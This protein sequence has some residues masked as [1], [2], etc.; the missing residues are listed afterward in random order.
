[1]A[2]ILEVSDL[3]R[4]IIRTSWSMAS[5][6]WAWAKSLTWS[7]IGFLAGRPLRVVWRG[8][9]SWSCCFSRSALFL[10]LVALF[11]PCQFLRLWHPIPAY[12]TLSRNVNKQSI[13]SAPTRSEIAPAHQ[14][15]ASATR[16]SLP[17]PSAL[18]I[19]LTV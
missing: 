10:S 1:M 7:L 6:T 4:F 11:I 2:A 8:P 15:H 18:E 19:C 9:S 13:R 12:P 3:E 17:L 5:S 16:L 14:L